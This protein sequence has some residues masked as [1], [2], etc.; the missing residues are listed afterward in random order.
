VQYNTD[1]LSFLCAYMADLHFWH[2]LC[3]IGGEPSGS[4]IK[5]LNL[6]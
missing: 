3:L 4:M 6:K 5:K 2:T 1:V